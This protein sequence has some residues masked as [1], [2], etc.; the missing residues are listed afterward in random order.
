MNR[1]AM[2]WVDDVFP[3]VAVR[4]WVM[5][6]PWGRRWLFA[7]HHHLARGVFKIGIRTIFA[8]YRRWARRKGYTEIQC[9]SVGVIQRFGSALNL[10]VHAHMLMMDGVWAKHPKQGRGL[11]FVRILEPISIM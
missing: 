11:H 3:K 4:Q 6:V 10:N 9:G 7:R 2:H 5:T 8:R 1:F